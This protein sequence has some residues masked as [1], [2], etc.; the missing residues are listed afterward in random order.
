MMDVEVTADMKAG[1]GELSK[2][3]V[4]LLRNSVVDYRPLVQRKT[5]S[6][7]ECGSMDKCHWK[8]IYGLSSSWF[9][10]LLSQENSSLM[11]VLSPCR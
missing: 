5:E 4:N 2:D 6:R 10:A 9:F 8:H 1:R 7:E 3:I 11:E